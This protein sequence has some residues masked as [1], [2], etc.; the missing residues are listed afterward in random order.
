MRNGNY[1][2]ESECGEAIAFQSIAAVMGEPRLLFRR[3]GPSSLVINQDI[4][5]LTLCRFMITCILKYTKQQH[6]KSVD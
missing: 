3:T 5:G 4:I 1:Q 2:I 6:S